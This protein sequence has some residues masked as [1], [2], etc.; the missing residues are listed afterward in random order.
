[1]EMKLPLFILC[2]CAAQIISGHLIPESI[3]YPPQSPPSG[4]IVGGS[5]AADGLAPFQCSMQYGGQHFC[6]CA[7][8]SSKFIITAGHCAEALDAS[9]ITVFV[10]SNKLSGN[11]AHYGIKKSK[12]HEKYDNPA[13][14]YDIAVLVVKGE[15]D[16]NEK[17]QP[18][19]LSAYEIPEGSVAQLTG[20]RRL[21]NSGSVP[22]QLQVI[23][24]NVVQ[25][26]E[27]KNMLGQAV[28]DS[29]ICTYNGEGEGACYGDSGG[30]LVYNNKLI[31][32]V[33]FGKPCAKG[34]PDAYAKISYLYDWINENTKSN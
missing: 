13:F 1:M 25:T 14:A 9:K 34:A 30:P 19:G 21:S 18:I 26:A 11:G 24:L 29:H 15:I 16:F 28:H 4:Y 33:N 12:I 3:F 22:D 6:G 32:V 2:I 8:L 17:V 10:G 27:C 7:I 23:E 31:G 20:W 5:N